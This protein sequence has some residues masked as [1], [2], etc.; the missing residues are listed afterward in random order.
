MVAASAGA[1]C[2]TFARR[3]HKNESLR[4]TEVRAAASKP[5]HTEGTQMTV[6]VLGATGKTGH[7]AAERATAFT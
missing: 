3:R 1:G 2:E 4:E 7:A 5:A 6:T